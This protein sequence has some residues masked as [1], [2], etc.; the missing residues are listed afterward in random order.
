LGCIG[1]LPSDRESKLQQRVQQTYGGG[2][3]W[4]VTL[5]DT[6]RLDPAAETVLRRRWQNEQERARQSGVT[7]DAEV[8]VRGLLEE[9]FPE[10]VRP[11]RLVLPKYRQAGP[12]V[13]KAIGFWRNEHGIF[14]DFPKPQWL[15]RRD[16]RIAEREQILA[17]LGSGFACAMCCGWSTCR[18]GCA[19]GEHNGCSDFTDGEWMWPEGLGHYVRCHDVILPEEFVETM[20]RN[21]WHVPDVADLVPPSMWKSDY[22]FWLEWIASHQRKSFWST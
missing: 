15:V 22:R 19:E 10:R 5:R 4:K 14:V 13:L 16:W 11:Q 8:F 18:F 2:P 1:Q 12:I 3:D 20:R 9:L 21:D 7:P 6:L 17:Y